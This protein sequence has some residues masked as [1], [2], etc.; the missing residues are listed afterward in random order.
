MNREEFVYD[1]YI[2]TDKTSI[3][4]NGLDYYG[5]NG[6]DFFFNN[7]NDSLL[8]GLGEVKQEFVFNAGNY[9]INKDYFKKSLEL[10][11]FF[12]IQFAETFLKDNNTRPYYTSYLE[13]FPKFVWLLDEFINNNF[14][15]KNPLGLLYNP[16]W[17]KFEVHPGGTRF[18]ITQFFNNPSN[19]VKGLIFGFKDQNL[20]EDNFSVIFKTKK[21]LINYFQDNC[22]VPGTSVDNGVVYPQFH[23]SEVSIE[24]KCIEYIKKLRIFFDTHYIDFPQLTPQELSLPFNY[25]EKKQKSIRITVPADQ[26]HNTSLKFY[27]LALAFLNSNVNCHGINIKYSLI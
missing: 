24:D 13:F 17:K 1:K 8:F 14:E 22:I 5:G 15:F 23:F 3:R 6:Y 25:K 12:D 9:G 21:E 10:G 7:L 11:I 19:K 26:E 2:A 4:I 16:I 27:A 20:T 18:P